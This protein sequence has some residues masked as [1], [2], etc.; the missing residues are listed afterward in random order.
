[1]SLS[2]EQRYHAT[3][4]VT[5][6][7]AVANVVLA[8]VKVLFGWLG[9]SSALFA[10]GIHSFSDWLTDLLVILAAKF[11]HHEADTE[12]P[13]GHE[14]IETAATVALS[15]L[16]IIVGIVIII[17]A[18]KKIYLNEI[19]QI[20][21]IYVLWIAAAS[22]IVNEIVY[23]YTK[24]VADRVNS[25]LLRANAL[26][27]R[28]DAAS[29]L[30]VLIGVA[31]DV[32]GIVWLDQVAAIVVGLMIIRMG[33]LI[34]WHNIRELVDT[35]VDKEM[36]NQIRQHIL[37]VPGVEAIHQLR[38]RKMAGRI[39]IDVHVIVPSH[40]SVSEGHHIGDQVLASLYSHFDSIRDIVVHVDSENDELY[41]KSALLPTRSELLP[42]LKAAWCDLPGVNDIKDIVLHYHGGKIEVVLVL[43]LSVSQGGWDAKILRDRYQHA[44]TT[45]SDVKK[46]K[47]LFI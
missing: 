47:L 19:Q 1:M 10:D 9:H 37:R 39:L 43:P 34:S 29:S 42:K 12:H 33:A 15:V 27:S 7:G 3:R 11:A 8:V 14:R 21:N 22:V 24:L 25:D 38:T 31:G 16:L 30:I 5:L 41:S 6:I 13:Y 4:R 46:V 45:F 18:I 26:H 44:I 35:G 20:P 32:F 2:R 28:S 17:D 23:R 40:I 36:L